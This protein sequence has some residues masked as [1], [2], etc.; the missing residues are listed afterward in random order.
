[1]CPSCLVLGK[2][3]EAE[4]WFRLCASSGDPRCTLT[5][6]LHAGFSQDHELYLSEKE[7]EKLVNELYSSKDDFKKGLG[8][9]GKSQT[10]KNDNEARICLYEEAGRC[11]F[12]KGYAQAALLIGELNDR[13]LMENLVHAA[14][15]GILGAYEKLAEWYLKKARNENEQKSRDLKNVLLMYTRVWERLAMIKGLLDVVI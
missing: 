5:C 6:A 14:K 10:G 3:R 8:A 2:D 13:R 7:G 1:M 9:Y 11:G 15:N 4:S 12:S